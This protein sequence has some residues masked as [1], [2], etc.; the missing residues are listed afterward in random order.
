MG[1]GLLLYFIPKRMGYTKV[2]KYLTISYSLIVLS[3]ILFIAFED[4]L[5]SKNDAKELVEEQGI[6]LA[7][8]FEL[9]NNES[10]SAI[11][12]Y[13]H[14]FTLQITATDKTKIINI[15]G[16]IISKQSENQFWTYISILKTDTM[17]LNELKIMKLKI[18]L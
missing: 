7:D 2:S 17:V 15:K 8:E 3:I 9:T 18:L 5:F 16:Q 4:Q 6:E 12:D 11:G 1:I 10:M 14:T 13:Y